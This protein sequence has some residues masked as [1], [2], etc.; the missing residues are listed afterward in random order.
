MGNIGN[1]TNFNNINLNTITDINSTS[2]V[3]EFE[4]IENKVKLLKNL[5]NPNLIVSD[6]IE[7]IGVFD[8]KLKLF[9]K[10]QLEKHLDLVISLEFLNS[11][12]KMGEIK[13]MIGKCNV[14]LKMKKDSSLFDKTANNPRIYKESLD[15]DQ[16]F[17]F[18]IQNVKSDYYISRHYKW[19][20]EKI[21]NL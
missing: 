7:N 4:K 15:A 20:E 9:I 21:K 10:E 6:E 13:E 16:I 11:I 2:E 12:R 1:S 14:M 19:E 18:F 17:L 3:T 8:D 5:E